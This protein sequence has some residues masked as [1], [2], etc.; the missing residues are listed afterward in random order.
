MSSTRPRITFAVPVFNGMPYL[1]EAIESI[2]GQSMGD[3][4]L[5]LADNA[6]TDETQDICRR[7]ARD[8]AR[9]Q[10]HRHE[11]NMGAAANFNYTLDLA[12]APY[13]KWAASDD[14]CGA[15]WAKDSLEALEA[16]GPEAVLAYC[17]VRWIDEQGEA[18]EDYGQGLPW[19]QGPPHERLACLLGD[20]VQSHLFK[21]SPICGV[22][23]TSVL[24]TTEGIGPF[25]GSDK[26]TLVEM[27]LRGRWL[28]VPE[29]HYRR[30]VHDRSSLAANRKPEDIARWFDPKRGTRFPMPRT[31]LFNGF[32]RAIQRAPLDRKERWRCL[33]VLVSF[34]R[35]E[36]RVLG[37][38]YKI[39]LK[40]RLGIQRGS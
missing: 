27:A 1:T 15:D 7:F 5:I 13:F 28:E 24:R 12:T 25:G 16:A 38:E 35:K 14:V 10:Y 31:T 40:E 3:L 9:V 34:F 39:K 21:C 17:W 19:T 29:L 20:P 36:W 30:R 8:D 11:A 6:S 23:R 2:L 26:V 33:R 37:G 32:L 18:I 22:S 4:Q